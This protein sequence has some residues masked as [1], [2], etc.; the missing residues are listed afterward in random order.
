MA[1]VPS[2]TV[3]LAISGIRGIVGDSLT[4]EVVSRYIASFAHLQLTQSKGT[5]II[6]GYDTRPAVIWIKHCVIGTLV[7]S[8][9]DVRDI[10]VVPTP[11]V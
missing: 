2:G 1:A 6:L 9:I 5:R 10:G 7:A 3:I 8:G 11:T 4:P